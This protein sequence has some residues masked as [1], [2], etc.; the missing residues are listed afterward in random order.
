MVLSYV[1]FDSEIQHGT[2]IK[3]Y[4]SKASLLEYL[5]RNICLATT[6][7]ETL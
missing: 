1:I 4:I 5:R 3:T 6:Y 2:Y 7:F